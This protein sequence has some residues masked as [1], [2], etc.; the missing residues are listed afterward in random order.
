MEVDHVFWFGD[1]N[2]RIDLDY[3]P[4]QKPEKTKI[5]SDDFFEAFEAVCRKVKAKKYR[6]LLEFDQLTQE[7]M[8]GNVLSGFQLAP[9]DF[10]PTFK[11]TRQIE[12]GHMTYND[13][14]IPSW[15]DRVLW[16]SMPALEDNIRLVSFQSVPV[17][18]TSDHI[19]VQARFDIKV[20]K[21][22]SGPLLGRLF[23]ASSL[24]FMEFGQLD[25]FPQ[26]DIAKARSVNFRVQAYGHP[27]ATRQKRG[28]CG[29]TGLPC[30]RWAPEPKWLEDSLSLEF[31]NGVITQIHVVLLVECVRQNTRHL[32]GSCIVPFAKLQAS[33]GAEIVMPLMLR[34]TKTEYNIRFHGHATS[35]IAKRSTSIQRA[36][37]RDL[38]RPRAVVQDMPL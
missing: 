33:N 18:R 2:Y 26:P 6:E 13:Q 35:L 20:H 22:Q 4:G 32:I 10:A 36:R 31:R 12:L 34:E 17:V 37:R 7:H 9:V 19:P 25:V 1:M 3:K 15:C 5:E 16:K 30:T 29:K 11:V 28:C 14:R 38:A 27:T 8:I 23:A 24:Y 21:L